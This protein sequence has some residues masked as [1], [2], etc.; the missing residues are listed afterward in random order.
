MDA[1]IDLANLRSLANSGSNEHFSACKALLKDGY[2]LM[3]SFIKEDLLREKKKDSWA[4]NT[5]LKA[6]TSGRGDRVI[7]YGEKSPDPHNPSDTQHFSAIYL[8]D[9]SDDDKAKKSGLLVSP[10][11]KEIDTLRSLF[12]EK[13][14]NYSREYYTPD[15]TDWSVIGNNSSPCT[16]IV[17]VDEFVF[18]ESDINYVNN[19]YEI[20]RQ[21]C[22][23]CQCKEM[24]IVI[25]TQRKYEVGKDNKEFEIPIN[26]IIRGIKGTVSSLG[27]NPSVT[28]VLDTEEHDR[29]IITNYK[30]F[31]SGASFKYF[32]INKTFS[33]KGST[34]NAHSLADTTNRETADKNLKK[35]QGYVDNSLE[36][37]IIGDKKSNL[38]KFS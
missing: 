32:S 17:I 11:G 22:E 31:V 25:I 34:F 2:N 35:F 28:L 6:F 38:L 20:I 18:A 4:I 12:I 7:S 16:D 14:G 27:I 30:K 1:Y 8:I 36:C 10:V 24:N 5:F 26:T 9:E 23:H 29:M 3:F 19:G 37:N 33:S 13:D 15:F 21:L